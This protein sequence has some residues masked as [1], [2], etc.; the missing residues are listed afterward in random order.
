[1]DEGVDEG[2]DVTSGAAGGDVVR[3]DERGGRVDEGV[4]VTIG[5]M[6]GV[7]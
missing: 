7:A 2:V 1:M 4:D 5:G 6:D 3:C